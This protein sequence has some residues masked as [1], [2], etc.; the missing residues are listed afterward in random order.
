MIEHERDWDAQQERLSAYLDGRLEGEERA[1]LDAHLTTCARCAAELTELRQVV[2]LLHALPAPALP[3]S[4][5]LPEPV[6]SQTRH[7][8]LGDNR[9]GRGAMRRWSAAIQWAGGIAAVFG[10]VLLLGSAL[11]GAHLGQG[12]M[13]GSTAPYAPSHAQ[14]GSSDTATP[15]TA[16]AT[17]AGNGATASGSPTS[18]ST[19]APESP[20]QAQAHNPEANWGSR[21]TTA[22]GTP[23]NG[24][25]VGLALVICGMLAFIL[26]RLAARS[27]RPVH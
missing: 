6:T 11:M 8:V 19:L 23:I 9:A 16:S 13:A 1:M 14:L 10:V 7:P 27:A 12:S 20:Q 5:A 21:N 18:G 2:R 15:G 25:I 17:T 26:G 22:S 3:R 24:A 4:F